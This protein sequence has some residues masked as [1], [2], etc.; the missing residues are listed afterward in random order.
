M[1]DTHPLTRSLPSHHQCVKVGFRPDM[2]DGPHLI[3]N[4]SFPPVQPFAARRNPRT[5]STPANRS[6]RPFP[7]TQLT[8]RNGSSCPIPAVD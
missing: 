2:T 3:G 5:R 1:T 7:V 8:I 4:G 6:S